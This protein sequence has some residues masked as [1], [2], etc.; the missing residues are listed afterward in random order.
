MYKGLVFVESLIF[1]YNV[2]GL[3]FVESLIFKYNVNGIV[4]VV[5]DIQ[6]QC[7]WISIRRVSDIQ[8]QIEH[9]SKLSSMWFDEHM[10]SLLIKSS[11]CLKAVTGTDS[12]GCK[13]A[14]VML[15]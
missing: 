2:K 8:I 12:L 3:V 4:F 7:K 11:V 10:Q 1:K 13:A 9:S 14:N 6:I 5:S 15:Y